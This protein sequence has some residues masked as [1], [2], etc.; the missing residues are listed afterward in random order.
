MS[1]SDRY[2]RSSVG[3][4]MPSSGWWLARMPIEP[5]PVRV[6]TISTSSLKTSP[7][8]VRTSAGNFVRATLVALGGAHDVVD[9]ALEQE[10][11]LRQVVVLAVED[12]LERADRLADRHVRAGR[13][14]EL[15]GHVERLA[16][17][18]LDLTGALHGHLVV[19]AELV[20]AEDR[21]D[22]LQL[23]VALQDRL[24]LVG[25]VVVLLA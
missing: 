20:D 23:L 19:V 24:D 16:Q 6:E 21:D 7:S 15:L 10:R 18:A 1:D 11:R 2:S 9:R 22:V 12:L 14:G 4:S 25:D 17:E 13:A 3:S 5:T 8:G